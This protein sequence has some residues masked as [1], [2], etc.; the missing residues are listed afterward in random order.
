[1]R[2]CIPSVLLAALLAGAH[3]GA[4]EILAD[5]IAAQ[6]GPDIV[7][8]SEVMNMVSATEGQMRKAGVSEREIAKLRAEGLEQMIEWRLLEKIV[9]HTGL[10]ATDAEVDEVIEEI[11][12]ANGLTMDQLK[13]SVISYDLTYQAYRKQLQRELERRKVVNALVASRVRVEEYEIRELYQERF[14]NQPQGGTQ[15]HIRQLLVTGGEGAPRDH[16]TAC[17]MTVE[18]LERIR[19]GDAS[20]EQVA[21]EVS[22]AAPEHGGDIGWL[23]E[24]SIASWMVDLLK[25]MQPGDIS[26]VM[27]LPFGCTILKLVERREHTPVEYETA[28]ERLASEVFERKLAEEYRTWMEELR[29]ESFIQRRGYFAAAAELRGTSAGLGYPSSERTRLP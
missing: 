24:D 17:E 21:R 27:E 9:R 28:K 15:V 7:L 4:E 10:S 23:H 26:K 16:Q 13:A 25:T 3:A 5:G 14:S 11:A 12:R 6:V 1:M 8:V 22:V 20:F 2:R 29:A 18:A 19:S